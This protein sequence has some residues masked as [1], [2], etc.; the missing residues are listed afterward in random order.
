LTDAIELIDVDR[1]R[2]DRHRHDPDR[3]ELRLDDIPDDD[4]VTAE[5][6]ARGE[7]VGVFQCE[8]S[9]ARN[10]LIKLGARAVTDLAVANAFF[11]P[12]PSLGGMAGTFVRRYRGQEPVSYLHPALEPILGST[13]GVLIF[14]EQIL[15]IA[16]EIA[17]LSWAQADHLRR[18]IKFQAGEMDEMAAQFI[19]GCQR[20]APHG[21]G[22]T[23]QQAE[24]LWSQIEPFSGYGFN[25]GHAMAYANVSYQSAY[26][27]A[28]W[29][30]AFMCARLKNWGGFHHP[31]MYMA[32]AMRLGI[33]VR[34]PHVNHSKRAFSLDWEA[35]QAVLW[36]GLSWVRD[37]RRSSVRA[38]VE[39]RRRQRFA[40]LRDL[41]MRVSLQSKELDHLI[42]CGALD[43]LGES[44]MAM[45]AE[46][47]S[48]QSSGH[49]LQLSFDLGLS[50][51]DVE[52]W[53]Q[54]LA[55]ERQVL[56]YPVS[57]FREPLK[58][59]TE[60]LPE[61]EGLSQLPETHQRLVNTAGVRLPGWT[62]GKG[63]YLWDGKTWV[64]VRGGES[65]RAPPVWE[66]VLLH[67]RWMARPWEL[68]WFQAQDLSRL[69][70]LPGKR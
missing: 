63:F 29:P 46:S 57:G 39:E 20:P 47:R 32:E 24:T 6:L 34:V 3:A 28:H 53:A 11:K 69:A 45:L 49:A 64:I 52:S 9:G 17:G 48:M 61:Y 43:G 4:P 19:Q 13:K 38:I 31:A 36:M 12:G 26:L 51:G 50:Q 42:Q 40:S 2:R 60:R 14:Q 58:L 27:K 18:G 70:T 55:W 15:R 67:G 8:S 56:G 66:P 44:R 37:L 16:V 65:L 5:M 68:S 41:A 33:E 21:P 1:H 25:Q 62:G 22:F 10:T 30:A 59:I 7:T 54:S 35:G 23:R